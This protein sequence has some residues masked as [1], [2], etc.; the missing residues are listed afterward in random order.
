VDVRDF[1][2]RVLA[3]SVIVCGLPVVPVLF[4]EDGAARQLAWP[5]L[6]LYAVAAVLGVRRLW[7]RVARLDGVINL[8]PAYVVL[9]IAGVISLAYAIEHLCDSGRGGRALAAVAFAAV[10]LPGSGWAVT[11]SDRVMWA[12]PT[13]IVLAFAFGLAVLAVSEGGTHYCLT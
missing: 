5:A 6:A 13:A 7:P 9:A 10:Y 12:W 8:L 4:L 3:G 2:P 11:K 1:A